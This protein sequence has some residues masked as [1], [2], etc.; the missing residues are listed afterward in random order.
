MFVKPKSAGGV[1]IRKMGA[2]NNA[3]LSEQTW[4]MLTEENNLCIQVLQSKYVWRSKGWE[5]LVKKPS[6]SAT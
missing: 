5:N 6:D 3:L 2:F 1:G 4:Q